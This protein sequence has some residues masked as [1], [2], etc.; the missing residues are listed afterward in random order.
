MIAYFIYYQAVKSEEFIK[1]PY[2]VFQD[3]A[4]EHVVR[5]S[6]VSADGKTLAETNVNEEG[7]EIRSYPQGRL[8][9][10]V[11]GY[12]THGK[13]GLE[14]QTNFDLLNSHEFILKQIAND[15]QNKKSK[16]DH[17]VSS[18]RYDLQK[19]A[20]DGLGDYDG[21]VVA[22]DPETG[23]ILAMVS[24]PDFD[25]N[26]LSE[27]WESITESDEGILVNRATQ[28]NFSPGSVF[29][30]ITVLE[31]FREHPN[32][33]EKYEYKCSGTISSDDYDKDLSCALGE[34]HG[35]V[36]L[37]ESFAE[38]CNTSFANIGRNLKLSEWNRL[39]EELMFNQ[40]LPI[41]LESKA[42]SFVLENSAKERLIMDTAIGQG[43]TLVSPLHMLLVTSAIANNGTLME[44]S[45]ID[46]IE[47][48]NGVV[49]ET[50]KPKTY[51]NLLSEKEALFLQD[52]MR[53]V[54]TE[55]TGTKLDVKDYTAYGKTGTAQVESKKDGKTNAW[56]VGYAENGDKKLAIAV[57]VENSGTGSKYAIPI[58]KSVFAKY[59]S[60]HNE[61]K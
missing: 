35:T 47:N 1:S 60:L 41:D 19:I 23:K 56:F 4:G 9:A 42:S 45:L 27:D 10:H 16:G 26:T 31:Y 6:I 15:I 51:Q 34:V 43:K 39:C 17:V 12:S 25:P 55:G 46:H 49:I 22:M 8:F 18:L 3:L 61:E 38:S 21:A 36:D 48:A 57:I 40:K 13:S 44:P 54:V 30:I 5:G 29:K 32:D 52:Y 37:K 7:E 33:Y 58:A 2:N 24:K 59:F 28:G 53:S 50:V 20:Y 14:N 11:V